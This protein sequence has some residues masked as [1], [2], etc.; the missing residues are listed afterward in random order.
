MQDVISTAYGLD[1]R[2]IVAPDWVNARAGDYFI[3]AVMPAGSTPKD[4]PQ[5][6][7]SLLVERFHLES[8]QVV[9]DQ[10]AYALVVGKKGV[11]LKPAN[12]M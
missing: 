5:L 1:P 4:I 8:H 6:M 10:R 2:Q 3:Q 12:E 9:V 11:K 7:R